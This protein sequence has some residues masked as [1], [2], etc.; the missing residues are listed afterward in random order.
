MKE[1]E[2][3]LRDP[4][5]LMFFL[6]PYLQGD[7]SGTLMVIVESRLSMMYPVLLQRAIIKTTVDEKGVFSFQ[8]GPPQAAGPPV[9]G[10]SFASLGHQPTKQGAGGLAEDRIVGGNRPPAAMAFPKTHRD[11]GPGAASPSSRIV[12]RK[13][14]GVPLGHDSPSTHGGEEG[15]SAKELANLQVALASTTKSI[16]ASERL[17]R[18]RAQALF[19]TRIS[20]LEAEN[21]EL[22]RTIQMLLAQ[23]KAFSFRLGACGQADPAIGTGGM[24]MSPDAVGR[25]CRAN[26]HAGARWRC[27]WRKCPHT[28][29][30]YQT[31]AELAQHVVDVHVKSQPK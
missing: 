24:S 29:R 17:A 18:M 26:G 5:T 11:V 16:L 7:E 28:A 8:F 2:T 15:A 21:S 4:K 9:H 1:S 23:V 27:R 20:R 31:K 22:R 12:S 3:L 14:P 30:E 25:H 19:E 13:R 10:G 6:G